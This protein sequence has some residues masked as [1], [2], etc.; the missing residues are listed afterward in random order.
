M[1]GSTDY[2]TGD[3]RCTLNAQR[4]QDSTANTPTSVESEVGISRH[5]RRSGK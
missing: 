1:T 5:D 3:Y 4:Q 2:S